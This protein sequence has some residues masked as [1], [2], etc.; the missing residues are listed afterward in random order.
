MGKYNGGWKTG[1]NNQSIPCSAVLDNRPED[2]VRDECIETLEKLGFGVW[3]IENDPKKGTR[4]GM[5]DTLIRHARH[6][7]AMIEFKRPTIKTADSEGLGY[8]AG[9]KQRPAQKVF[10]SEW[11]DKGGVYLLVD[12]HATLVDLL[13][14]Y[15]VIEP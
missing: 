6:G 13:Q 14:Q 15:G 3:R 10:Q 8:Q 11:Q 2:T 9:G 5:P 12:S 4:S 7:D 1:K